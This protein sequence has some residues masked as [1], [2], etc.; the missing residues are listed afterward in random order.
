MSEKNQLNQKS[1]ILS[2]ISIKRPVFAAVISGLASI[3]DLAIR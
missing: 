1:L 3:Q 2:D